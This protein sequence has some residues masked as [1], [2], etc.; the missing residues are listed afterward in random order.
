MTGHCKIALN[1]VCESYVK[2]LNECQTP[3]HSVDA[4][5]GINVDSGAPGA[6]P[7]YSSSTLSL[8]VPFVGLADGNEYVGRHYV[9]D[10]SATRALY[11]QDSG[12]DLGWLFAEQPVTQIVAV[13]PSKTKGTGA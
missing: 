10:I 3:V 2:V 12:D 1:E 7:L 8:G 4:P 5:L 9:C 11:T 6:D 13:E